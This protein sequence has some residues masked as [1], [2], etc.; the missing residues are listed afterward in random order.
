M[1]KN[2]TLD[3]IAKRIN[4][5]DLR[6]KSLFGKFDR[7]VL[8][9]V[10]VKRIETEVDKLLDQRSILTKSQMKETPELVEV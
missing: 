1:N 3:P 9:T 8:G 5:I 10:E 4:E 6:V 7:R 2:T